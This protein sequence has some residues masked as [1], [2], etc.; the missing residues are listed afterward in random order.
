MT[1]PWLWIR[2]V[3]FRRGSDW[4]VWMM[5]HLPHRGGLP[6]LQGTHRNYQGIWLWL[7]VLYLA[8]YLKKK[9]NSLSVLISPC[10]S[11][12]KQKIFFEEKCLTLKKTMPSITAPPIPAPLLSQIAQQ[13][14]FLAAFPLILELT[15]RKSGTTWGFLWVVPFTDTPVTCDHLFPESPWRQELSKQQ[16]L[17]GNV[18]CP[19]RPLWGQLDLLEIL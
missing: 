10:F 16:T 1:F 15:V 19:C 7:P 11:L 6:Q 18:H 12:Q 3:F 17:E 9:K 8:F 2:R 5:N 13:T 4:A 14:C